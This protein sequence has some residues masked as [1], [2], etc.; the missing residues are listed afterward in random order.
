MWP[1]DIFLISLYSL[2][3]VLT[4][5]LD[6]ED[7]R[8]YRG[9]RCH[10]HMVRCHWKHCWKVHAYIQNTFTHTYT[11]CCVLP[12]VFPPLQ[13][14]EH[15]PY[16]RIKVDFSLS[17]CKD[18]FL[19]THQSVDWVFHTPEEEIRCVWVGET[20]WNTRWSFQYKQEAY[21]LL[22][23]WLISCSS[24]VQQLASCTCRQLL[25]SVWGMG[26]FSSSILKRIL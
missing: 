6:L 13:E 15:K 17:D 24:C 8:S 11:H 26:P 4:A 20:W 12:R 7:V 9:E 5:T 10:P 25:I 21:C 14:Y 18:T 23:D 22:C 3:E 1:A 2:Q 19:P 16:Q